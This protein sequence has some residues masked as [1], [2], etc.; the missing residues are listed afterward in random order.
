MR[1][2]RVM[3]TKLRA[4][5]ATNRIVRCMARV[6]HFQSIAVDES[7][8]SQISYSCDRRNFLG[9][10]GDTDSPTAIEFRRKT[11]WPHRQRPRSMCSLAG[12]I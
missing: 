7:N 5:W 6:S 8:H 2:Q 9:R 4:I 12:S 1:C 3:A 11:G 10:Y